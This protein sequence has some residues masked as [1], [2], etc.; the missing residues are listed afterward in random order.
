MESLT[1]LNFPALRVGLI[2]GN[3]ENKIWCPI[4]KKKYQLTPEEW[5]RQHVIAY[6]LQYK[7]YPASW[8]SVEKS[9]TYNNQKKRW[10]IAVFQPNGNPFLLVE[11]KAPTVPLNRDVYEQLYMY[12]NIVQSTHFALSNGLEHRIFKQETISI[13]LKE[14]KDFPEFNFG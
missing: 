11:C 6:L 3:P 8:I 14:L 10:D 5:V 9:L 13:K 1:A 12:Q 7:K 4:R 2:S